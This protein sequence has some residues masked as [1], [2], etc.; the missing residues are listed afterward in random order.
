MKIMGI[1]G[2]KPVNRLPGP[3][4]SGFGGAIRSGRI[5][6]FIETSLNIDFTAL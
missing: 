5:K 2:K 3:D 6:L 4:A 1:S